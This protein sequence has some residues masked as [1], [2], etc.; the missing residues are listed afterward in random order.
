[1]KNELTI[2]LDIADVKSG[3]PFRGQIQ[4]TPDGLT[5]VVQMKHMASFINPQK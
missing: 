3:Y 1:M 5:K 4:D 2:L